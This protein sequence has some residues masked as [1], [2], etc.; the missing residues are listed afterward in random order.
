[1]AAYDGAAAMVWVGVRCEGREVRGRCMMRRVAACRVVIR[2]R[3]GKMRAR[4][5]PV[6]V[7]T[8]RHERHV[9]RPVVWRGVW[10]P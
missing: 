3:T 4:T 6:G 5:A 8:P 2:H 10:G 1:M 9:A 7:M